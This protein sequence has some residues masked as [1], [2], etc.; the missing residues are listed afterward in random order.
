MAEWPGALTAV[1]LNSP[2]YGINMKWYEVAI[3]NAISPLNPEAWPTV[4]SQT[5]WEASSATFE[6]QTDTTSKERW[7]LYNQFL[8]SHMDVAQ[9]F[10]SRGWISEVKKH[11]SDQNLARIS[12][13]FKVPT[14]I[15][16]AGKDSYVDINRQSF[17]KTQLDTQL[18][19]AK[20]CLRI[21]QYPAEYH[22]IWRG[23][24]HESLFQDVLKYY[25]QTKAC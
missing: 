6:G 2:L 18:P 15:L 11:T 25:R 21:Q 13:G 9:A 16:Q 22:S 4:G 14:L 23:V 12:K 5:P 20:N 24:F 3:T 10:P 1:V 17:V 19:N 8:A 7:Q